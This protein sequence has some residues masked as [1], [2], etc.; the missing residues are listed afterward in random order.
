MVDKEE[1]VRKA[2]GHLKLLHLKKMQDGYKFIIFNFTLRDREVIAER[3]LIK[4]S[5]W[6]A[7]FKVVFQQ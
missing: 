6:R 3:R 1:L 4:H 7:G 5:L 2:H